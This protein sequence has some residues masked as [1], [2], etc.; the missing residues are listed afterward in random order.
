[1]GGQSANKVYQES[2]IKTNLTSVL[3]GGRDKPRDGWKDVSIMF[4]LNIFFNIFF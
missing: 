1:M 4:Y 2:F 3:M